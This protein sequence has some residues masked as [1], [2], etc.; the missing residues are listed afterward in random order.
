[1]T[2]LTAHVT[3]RPAGAD[4]S[5][6]PAW[7]IWRQHRAAFAGLAVL[8]AAGTVLFTL[9]GLQVHA[10]YS[11]YLQQL[12]AT[13]ASGA[14]K[15]LSWR[16]DG[17]PVAE[18]ARASLL[19]LPTA[20]GLFLGAP[21]AAR[22]FETSTFRFSSTQGVSMRRQLARKLLLL[23]AAAVIVTCAVSLL[24]AWSCQPLAKLGIA[25][26]W[27]AIAFHDTAITLPAWGVAGFALGV[28]AGAGIRR[29][30]PAMIAAA[31]GVVGAM[32][33]GGP[34]TRALLAT[35]HLSA[36][37]VPTFY[38]TGDVTWSHGV[39]VASGPV[40]TLVSE[41]AG[42]LGPHGSWQVSGWLIGAD[43]QRLPARAA[44]ML[45]S[46]VPLRISLASPPV[47]VR[48][49]LAAHHVSY[50]IGYQPASRYWLFQVAFAAILVLLAAA[51]SF[52]AVWLIGR[53][54]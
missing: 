9:S 30:I 19:V 13:S 52:L 50:W 10:W 6:G 53:R 26:R 11:A 41:P 54:S 20:F 16:L 38:V 45:L 14:C 15:H 23:G 2:T 1:L 31:G 7:S 18:R 39:P 29:T 43:G 35:A 34:A 44:R 3:R 49:W 47:R 24:A 22:E 8:L 17:T 46:R 40:T 51:A 25:S 48:G 21:L 4:R 27:T 33:A 42:V 36:R 28:L 12:C 37:G 32:L 5:P